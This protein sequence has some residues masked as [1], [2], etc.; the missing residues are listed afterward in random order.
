MALNGGCLRPFE[1]FASTPAAVAGLF[2]QLYSVCAAAVELTVW[3]IVP[4]ALDTKGM[5]SGAWTTAR[6]NATGSGC[7]RELTF[8]I[9]T[10]VPNDLLITVDQ[11][12]AVVL[13]KLQNN[14]ASSPPDYPTLQSEYNV[15][16]QAAVEPTD[17]AGS[18]TKWQQRRIAYADLS[19]S[20]TWFVA[21][22]LDPTP[23][24]GGVP[25]PPRTFRV[26]MTWGTDGG[27]FAHMSRTLVVIFSVA[28]S[29]AGLLL[30]VAIKMR[31][32]ACR[33]D[34]AAKGKADAKL[35]KIRLMQQGRQHQDYM[36]L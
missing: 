21:I 8:T 2:G 29:I 28:G 6:L 18:A 5:D 19:H 4:L 11:A 32:D 13:L 34:R 26:R 36:R 10:S 12:D 33:R 15:T 22:Y 3:H 30:M 9:S 25:R 20:Q 31:V 23:G 7:W 16:K 24:D 14:D 27:S 17:G 35:E 1:R